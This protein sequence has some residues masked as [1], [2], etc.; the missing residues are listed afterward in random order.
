[1]VLEGRGICGGKAEARAL[2]SSA[3]IAGWGGID[4]LTGTIIET[5]HPLQGISFSGKVLVFPGAKGSSSWSAYFH[6]TRLAKSA[7]AALVFTRMTT[8]IALG[9]VVLR[10]PA[11][12]VSE[13]DLFELIENDD[14]VTVDGDMGT[15]A[16]S[17]R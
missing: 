7:P 1:M 2:V 5:N 15:V 10:V 13:Q 9:A 14:L 16:I 12:M 17:K 3:A 11:V 6:I 8:R 4:P